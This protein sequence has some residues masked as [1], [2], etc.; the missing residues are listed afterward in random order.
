MGAKETIVTSLT[1][2]VG[3]N[4]QKLDAITDKVLSYN[5]RK[6]DKGA[7]E[8]IAGAADQPLVIG[9]IEIP[10]YVLEDETRVLSQSGMFSGLG[11][12]RRGLVPVGGGDQIPRFA[13]SKAINPFISEDLMHGLTNP[14]LF[15]VNGS[16]AYGFSATILP[17]ICKAVLDA[18]RAGNLNFQQRGLAH[19]CEILVQGL[20]TVGIVALVDEATGYQRIREQRALATILERFLAEELQPWAKTFPFEFYSQMCRLKNWPGIYAVKRPSLIGRYTND[21]VYERLGPGLLEEL[22]IR[23]PVMSTGYRRHKH[24]QWFTPELGHPKLK[25]HLA[26]VIAI[27]R[28]SRSWNGFRANLQKAFPKSGEQMLLNFETPSNK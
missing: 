21:I 26:G 4:K 5:P 7:L 27:M 6:E 9:D 18:R 22:K 25:E 16:E 2:N 14:I 19:R 23:N 3:M 8:V 13:A 11:L 10:C 12:A 15:T 28:I 1:R 17:K 24:H 20:A